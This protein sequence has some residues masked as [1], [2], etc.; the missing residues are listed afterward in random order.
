MNYYIIKASNEET[1]REIVVV[2][3]NEA[4]KE[5]SRMV[6]TKEWTDLRLFWAE[7]NDAG[8]IVA[9]RNIMNMGC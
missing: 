4:F 9:T 5:Y 7:V 3:M 6:K 2:G 8:V 1:E